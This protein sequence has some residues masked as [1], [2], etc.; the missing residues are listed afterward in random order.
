MNEKKIIVYYRERV[1]ING[2]QYE[3]DENGREN[4]FDNSTQ[5][6]TLIKK[7]F[8]YK[9][10]KKAFEGENGDGDE[11]GS[12]DINIIFITNE[13]GLILFEPDRLYRQL[14]NRYKD[15]KGNEI[16]KIY[17]NY[18]NEFIDKLVYLGGEK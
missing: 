8:A 3:E 16:N 1:C 2:V 13:N 14:H 11:S 6:K 12:F 9:D 7:E 10:I 4:C 18:K 15:L 5:T 17:E